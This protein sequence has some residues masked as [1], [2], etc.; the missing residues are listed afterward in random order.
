[1]AVS[2]TSLT[3][4]YAR[5]RVTARASPAFR[6]NRKSR[7]SRASRPRCSSVHSPACLPH[8]RTSPCARWTL[9][10]SIS[11]DDFPLACPR[12]TRTRSST[13]LQ[14]KSLP[15][16]RRQL[17]QLAPDLRHN[18]RH[19]PVTRP[20]LLF[21]TCSSQ[22]VTGDPDALYDVRD[23]KKECAYGGVTE[24]SR[25]GAACIH[26]ATGNET[27]SGGS[28]KSYKQALMTVPVPA[29]S[30]PASIPGPPTPTS[31]QAPATPT[32]ARASPSPTVLSPIAASVL[33][34]RV[35][36]QDL[37][38]GQDTNSLL[39]FLSLSPTE[40]TWTVQPGRAVCMGCFPKVR[41]GNLQL[42]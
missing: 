15:H 9:S 32:S 24:I 17:R 16:S 39:S 14:A 23:I 19:E 36:R 13:T 30:S 35:L 41:R 5:S 25:A 8:R 27:S 29:P 26:V 21:D 22:H 38:W 11:S 6:T 20:L 1:M 40:R 33:H 28:A 34:R 3:A 37:V 7:A 12:R 2:R 31:A 42:R 18:V 10:Q 4:R